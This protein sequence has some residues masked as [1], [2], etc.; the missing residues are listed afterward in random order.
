MFTLFSLSVFYI[1]KYSLYWYF[2]KL[3]KVFENVAIFVI[4]V[5]FV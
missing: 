2:L 3:E 4:L 5:T 1:L